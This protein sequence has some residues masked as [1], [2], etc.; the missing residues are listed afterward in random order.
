MKNKLLLFIYGL[1]AAFMP[2]MG[3][4]QDGF[5][6]PGELSAGVFYS[7]DNLGNTGVVTA[8]ALTQA[9]YGKMDLTMC[10]N[11][12]LAGLVAITADPIC[13]TTLWQLW[14]APSAPRLPYSRFPCSTNSK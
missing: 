9:L 14:L 3:M 11:G 7:P 5:N 6:V 13:K 10:L 4:S 12:A 2:S 8:M 1:S